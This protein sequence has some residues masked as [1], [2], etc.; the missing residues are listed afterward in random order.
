MISKNQ[1]NGN[2]GNQNTKILIAVGSKYGSTHEIAMK[3]T[4]IFSEK[5]FQVDLINLNERKL[6]KKEQIEKYSGI[7]LG[8]GIY[9]GKWTPK[10]KKF[11]KKYNS[12][13]KDKAL[14][15]FVVCGEAHDPNRKELS[16]TKFVQ[17]YLDKF[18][19]CPDFGAVFP[20]VIDFSENTPYNKIEL[21]I[22][23]KITKK[24]GNVSQNEKNDFRNWKD[25]EEFARNYADMFHYISHAKSQ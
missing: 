20:G 10:I 8:S 4:E 23:K 17:N 25:I 16:Q 14:A 5:G 3:I 21:K 6:S 11:I 7:L 18:G 15:A 24:E 22:L 13:L 19:I 2:E 1:N 9:A 12:F